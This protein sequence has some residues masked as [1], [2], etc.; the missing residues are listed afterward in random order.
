MLTQEIATLTPTTTDNTIVSTVSED[1]FHLY[2]ND[3]LDFLAKKLPDPPDF[4]DGRPQGGTY[5]VKRG[6]RQ[7]PVRITRDLK[8]GTVVACIDGKTT[9]VRLEIFKLWQQCGRNAV[10]WDIYDTRMKTGRW[11]NEGPPSTGDNMPPPD[12]VHELLPYTTKQ[13][14]DWLDKLDGKFTTPKEIELAAEYAKALKNLCQKA[15]KLHKEE[16]DV[17]LKAGKKVDAKYLRP[18]DEADAELGRMRDAVKA[19]DDVESVARAEQEAAAQAAADTRATEALAAAAALPPDQQLAKMR[20]LL[21]ALAPAP[22][23][24]AP[25]KYADSSGKGGFNVKPKDFAVVADQDALYAAVRDWAP[26]VACLAKI[27]QDALDKSGEILAGVEVKKG[28]V[29]R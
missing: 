7:I 12:E 24:P 5:A 19:F 25:V 9:Q 13:I 6:E 17:H 2:W 11:P 23:A 22:A 14:R 18:V 27:A 15:K 8:T 1:E 28:T 21:P 10:P 3:Y 20:E 29:V 16:K 26:V 4:N